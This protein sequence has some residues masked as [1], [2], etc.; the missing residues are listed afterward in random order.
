MDLVAIADCW[1]LDHDG[2]IVHIWDTGLSIENF[3]RGHRKNP[4]ARTYESLECLTR[5]LSR[6]TLEQGPGLHGAGNREKRTTTMKAPAKKTAAPA[7]KAAA[8]APAKKVA[9]K[10]KK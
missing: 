1:A 10:K 2:G 6:S 9:A 8:K 3:D 5:I 7:K 4:F